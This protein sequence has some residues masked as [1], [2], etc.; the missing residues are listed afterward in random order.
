VSVKHLRVQSPEGLK[1]LQTGLAGYQ[2]FTQF[3]LSRIR[4]GNTK[5]RRG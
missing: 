5:T 2:Y 3:L 1:S 4:L